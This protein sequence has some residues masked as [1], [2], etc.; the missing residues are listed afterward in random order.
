MNKKYGQVYRKITAITLMMVIALPV[1]F[2]PTHFLFIDHVHNHQSD[3]NTLSS[4]S[5]HFNCTIDDFQLTEVTFHS[6][7][8]C[9]QLICHNTALNTLNNQIYSERN[10]IL[11]LCL[12]APPL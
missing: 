12:R 11:T 10:S 1:I 9:S 3:E 7:I 5:K 4:E 2:Q 8:N 6:H